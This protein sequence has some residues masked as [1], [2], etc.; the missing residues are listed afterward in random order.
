[1]V[2]Y[3]AVEGTTL[4]K[5]YIAIFLCALVFAGCGGKSKEELY[6][7]G[8]QKVKNTNINGAI[9]LF[10]NALE[11]DQ[12]YF[13]ARYQ[14][15]KAYQQAGKYDQSEKEFQKA[16]RL[17][18]GKSDIKLEIAKI[19]NYTN[20]PDMAI[21]EVEAYLKEH[22]QEADALEILGN[23][24]AIK[25]SPEEAEKYLL[26]ALA[27]DPARVSAKLT[28]AGI[29]GAQG[30]TQ[31]ARRLLAE[32]IKSDEKNTRAWYMLGAMEV[33]AGNRPRALEAFERIA[34]I[35]PED[36]NAVYQI[37]LLQLDSGDIAKAEK[38][39]AQI[40]GKFPKS[41]QGHRLMGLVYYKQKKFKE[42]LVEL[43]S[44]L[45]QQDL[46]GYYY[47]GLT[48]YSLGELENAISQFRKVLDY[49]PDSVQPRLLVASILLKQKRVDDA[50]AEAKKAVESDGRNAQAHNILGSAYIA[51]GLLDEGTAE[52]NRALELD[53]RLV[54]AHLKKGALQLVK[55]KVKEGELE[56]QTA[57]QVAPEALNTRFLLA[58]YYMRQQKYGKAVTVLREGITGGKGDALLYNAIAGAMFADK[59]EV[60]GV[61]NLQKAKA[62]NP[63][64][65]AP[66]FALAA[67]YAAKGDVERSLAEYRDVLKT[68]PQNLRAM[69]SIAGVMEKKG[70]NAEALGYYKKGAETKKSG[71]YIALANYYLRQKQP[72]KAVNT[73][74][75]A[76]KA[77]A[78]DVAALELRGKI[79]LNEKKYKKSL[80]AFAEL[81]SVSPDRGMAMQIANY[82]AMKD[83]RNAV[84]GAEKII[85]SKPGSAA[86]YIVL[87]SVYQNVQDDKSAIDALRKGL[88]IE[89]A[90][91]GARM[92]LGNTYARQKDYSQALAVFEEAAKRSPR[93]PSPHFSQG[94]VYLHTGRKQDAVRKYSEA[95]QLSGN[96]VPALNNLAILYADGYG[97]KTDALKLALR[98]YRLAPGN[99]GIAD[100]LGY[101]LLKNGRKED[102]WKAISRAATYLPRNPSVQYH[103]ALVYQAYGDEQKAAKSLQKALTLGEFTEAADAKYLLAKM[104]KK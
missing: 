87:A 39:A 14:L 75:D 7:D 12:N 44:S 3:Q 96:H 57:V 65:P 70:K 93:D 5:K 94:S 50:V 59:K 82:L 56:L 40:L 74:D 30:N 95:L 31:N 10:K 79:Y 78:K 15:A 23:A 73:L 88:T 68:D 66:A 48:H 25:K 51:K 101:V 20:K 62:L 34:R 54:D 28:L 37:G 16:L 85:K 1:M 81:E 90:N 63:A 21:K 103:L 83:T 100:T 27:L 2:N 36:A 102:A 67:Y 38:S 43:Q 29:Y 58:T 61:Q 19:Y 92:L 46:T 76:I 26:Q 53:P 32:I 98:A 99:A 42:A 33:A 86:G 55:G 4:S 17:N 71:G 49:R 69:H 72:D 11:K 22:P 97:N 52:L 47:L 9:V 77:D 89:P 24:H 45:K 18:P 104:G 60:A 41:P 8:L 80:K 13:D 35:S 84:Q 6:A 91:I 64:F